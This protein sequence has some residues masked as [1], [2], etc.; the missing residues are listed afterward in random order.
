MGGLTMKRGIA[1][2]LTVLLYIAMIICV[3]IFHESELAMFLIFVVTCGIS[4][5]LGYCMRCRHCGTWFRK[6]MFFAEYCPE[7]GKKLED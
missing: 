6:G 3:F 7:C 5:Y 2:L 1:Q 4:L